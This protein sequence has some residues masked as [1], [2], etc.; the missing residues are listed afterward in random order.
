MSPEL[1]RSYLRLMRAYPRWYRRERG[2]ELLTTLLDDARPGQR[3]ASRRDVVDLLLSGVRA[4]FRPP[5]R[6]TAYAAAV[7][8]AGYLG[9]AGAAGAVQLTDYPGPPTDAQAVAAARAALPHEPHNVPGPAVHCDLMC[10]DWDGRDDVVAFDAP[11]DRTDRVVIWYRAEQ[12]A[13]AA[14]LEQARRRLE[15][16]SW[17]VGDVYDLDADYPQLDA[18]K[19]GITIRLSA[20][21][22]APENGQVTAVVAK[23]FSTTATWALLIGGAGGLLAGWLL[24]VWVLHRARGHRPA[25]RRALSVVALPGLAAA[26]GAL[27]LSVLFI[28]GVLVGDFS[29]KVVQ[30]PLFLLTFLPGFAVVAVSAALALILAALPSPYAPSASP[31][32][33]PER[34]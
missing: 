3:R 21:T 12:M 17:Q 11:P 32:A 5:R 23:D 33:A 8:A 15:A 16:A 29:P 19:D 31:G 25:I 10:P 7:V 24:A 4:R 1:R 2:A 14:R 9:L 34:A 18:G 22:V 26:G 20:S 28:S 6:F 30:A 13:P 27:A